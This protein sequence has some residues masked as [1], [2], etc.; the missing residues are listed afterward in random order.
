VGR[1]A[2]GW[3]L[4]RGGGGARTHRVPAAGRCAAGDVFRPPTHR[5]ILSAMVGTGAQLAML[6]LFTIF[7][8]IAGTMFEVRGAPDRGAR[9]GAGQGGQT[10][11]PVR[12]CRHLLV[13]G[14]V[15]KKLHAC[16]TM[17]GVRGAHHRPGGQCVHVGSW[18]RGGGSCR[19]GGGGVRD[20]RHPVCPHPTITKPAG[21][22]LKRP[23]PLPPGLQDRGSILTTFIVCYALTSFVGGYVS[24]GVYTR[25]EGRHWIQCMLLTAGGEAGVTAHL[26][27]AAATL[28]CLPLCKPA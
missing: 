20:P 3:Q 2:S 4:L 18:A 5:V 21:S 17:F 10:G 23:L 8:V 22:A 6:G 7:V 15:E 1:A 16:R 13:L 25:M 14:D 19:G 11:G 26:K 28:P 27:P 12:A 9:R 24:G